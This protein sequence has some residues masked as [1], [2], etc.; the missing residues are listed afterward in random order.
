[1]GAP[2][3][4]SQPCQFGGH[5]HALFLIRLV[6]CHRCV[7]RLIGLCIVAKSRGL[8]VRLTDLQLFIS[9]TTENSNSLKSHE[10][11]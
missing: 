6:T 9:P 2:Y 1:M 7:W 5:R 10:F 3:G 4:M 11:Y 8:S